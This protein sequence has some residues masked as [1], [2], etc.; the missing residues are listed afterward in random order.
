MI[1][2]LF[3]LHWPWS[4]YAG[5]RRRA[6]LGLGTPLLR[7]GP[8]AQHLSAH[9]SRAEPR[10][11]RLPNN[12]CSEV[13]VPHS[14]RQGA[15]GEK[16]DSGK[17]RSFQAVGA[18]KDTSLTPRRRL[19]WPGGADQIH[20]RHGHPCEQGTP[21]THCLSHAMQLMKL[22]ANGHGAYVV[23]ISC[24]TPSTPPIRSGPSLD[25]HLGAHPW[26]TSPR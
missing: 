14:T 19:A 25:R 11:P 13:S 12:V 4:R 24:Y 15:G 21:A 2:A 18:P 20:K 22:V 9:N 3:V 23:P 16:P 1:S 6:A 7:H 8:P 10:V 26:A 5:C 17:R